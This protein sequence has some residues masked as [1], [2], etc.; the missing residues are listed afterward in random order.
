MA[1]R[2]RKE[3][4]NA[5][6]RYRYSDAPFTINRRA[7]RFPDPDTILWDHV[8]MIV[9]IGRYHSYHVNIVS[10]SVLW[11]NGVFLNLMVSAGSEKKRESTSL[12]GVKGEGVAGDVDSLD[13]G[14]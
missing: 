10:A 13:T 4:A 6:V 14:S 9:V 11:R 8:G 3:A 5:A 1:A 2:E 12:C 7:V